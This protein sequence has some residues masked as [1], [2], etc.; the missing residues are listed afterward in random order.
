MPVTRRTGWISATLDAM[1]VAVF[2]C[3]LVLPVLDRFFGLDHAPPLTERRTPAPLPGAPQDLTA[4]R[5]FPSAFE[6]YWNDAFGFRRTLVRSYNRMLVALGTSPLPD[7]VIIG[8]DDWMFYAEYRA[9]EDYQGTAPFSD[10]EMVR[11]QYLLEARRNWLRDRGI[12]YI[13]FVAPN[14]ETLYPEEMPQRLQR[15]TVHRLDQLLEFLAIHSDLEIVDPRGLLLSAKTEGDVCRKTDSHWSPRGALLVEEEIAARLGQT[16]PAVRPLAPELL[17]TQT[18]SGS[19]DLAGMLSLSGLLIERW[20]DIALVRPRAHPV[21][22]PT[23]ISSWTEID[24][25]TLPRGVFFHDSFGRVQAPYIAEHFSHLRQAWMKEM[26]P[27]IVEGE[28]A[29]VVVQEMCERFL[30]VPVPDESMLLSDN[31]RVHASFDAS[32]IVLFRLADNATAIVPA[33]TMSVDSSVEGAILL[34]TKGTPGSAMLPTL[35]VPQG[36]FPVLRV[37]L[38]SPSDGRLEAWYQTR[39]EPSYHESRRA[40]W[41]LRPGSNTAWFVLPI[42]QLSGHIR[43]DL[44]SPGTYRLTGLEVRAVSA[45]SLEARHRVTP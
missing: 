31:S 7:Q 1:I 3:G 11:W 38:E 13:L 33:T 39:D 23:N 30:L 12:P 28:R 32:P 6:R 16:F 44:T 20:E 21:G 8:S 17:R 2:L 9:L 37:Q 10:N 36:A 14:K 27:T 35:D 4:L 41:P 45:S 34:Q 25:P 26:D 18:V 5:A 19:G 22:T 24:D 40:W 29:Q 42:P 15:G 43:L